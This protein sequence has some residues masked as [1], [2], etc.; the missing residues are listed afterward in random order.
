[1][2]EPGASPRDDEHG[3]FDVNLITA[4]RWW[5]VPL[6]R[7]GFL[8]SK[9]PNWL[10]RM[11][12][13]PSLEVYFK[14][15]NFLHT[16]R[17]V[18]LGRFP[19][20]SPDQPR[21][22]ASPRWVVFMANFDGDWNAYFRTFMEAMG[23]G[24]YD[25][26]GRSVGYPG[27]PAAGTAYQLGDW[28]NTRIVPSLH[29]YAAYPHATANDVRAAARVRRELRS[30]ALDLKNEGVAAST[31]V[32][33]RFDDLVRRL[34]HCLGSV[35]RPAAGRP[36]PAT[37]A[38][39]SIEGVVAVFPVLPGHEDDIRSA[40]ADF[41]G[42]R[43]NPFSI[44]P[45]THFARLVLLQRDEVGIYPSRDQNEGAGGA[46]P[47]GVI[48]RDTLANSYLLVAADFDGVGDSRAT[49][50]RFFRALYR[51]D[52]ARVDAV[53]RHCWGYASVNDDRDFSDLAWRCRR[54]VLR[55]YLDY[56]DESLRSVLA[57]LSGHEAFVELVARRSRG[58][59]ITAGALIDSL[60]EGCRAGG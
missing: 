32:A 42:G 33:P 36:P 30:A 43:A 58:E 3:L 46:K 37:S 35:G 38:E 8:L 1:M 2:H 50:A 21:E 24:V 39:G 44:V 47:G 18:S 52:A 16:A 17:W 23:E 10:S 49:S 29:Y 14:T 12:D 34:R 4:T 27:F 56:R 15:F 51:S 6:Q 48:V 22:P 45:G 5:G 9:T 20:L 19:H 31:D 11:F 40:A 25:I 7:F 59:S 53:W 55:E 60:D 28:L 54:P 57:A 41:G 13:E 26:W